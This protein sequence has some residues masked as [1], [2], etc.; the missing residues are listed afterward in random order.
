MKYILAADK[1]KG[2]GVPAS[3]AQRA[4]D[5][6]AFKASYNGVAHV[7]NILKEELLS[8]MQTKMFP[9]DDEFNTPGWENKQARNIG[10]I[11]ALREV[12]ELLP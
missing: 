6:E 8:R 3:L 7:T 1:T 10:Y 9:K 12:V 11:K 5:K 2:A 4:P